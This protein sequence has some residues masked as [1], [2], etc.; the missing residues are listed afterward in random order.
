MSAFPTLILRPSSSYTFPTAVGETESVF[1]HLY[2]DNLP[3]ILI[4]LTW[5]TVLF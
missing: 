1:L 5:L 3:R 4:L 2:L